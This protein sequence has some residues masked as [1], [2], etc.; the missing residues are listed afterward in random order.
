MN[1]PRQLLEGPTRSSKMLCGRRGRTERP[2]RSCSVHSPGMPGPVGT[3]LIPGYGLDQRKKSRK[4]WKIFW[5]SWS[6]ASGWTETWD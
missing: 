5:I 4:W 3:G 6:W 2:P 1:W